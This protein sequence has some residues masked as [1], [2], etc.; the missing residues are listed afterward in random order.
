MGTEV[1]A[2]KAYSKTPRYLRFL[3]CSAVKDH[4]RSTTIAQRVTMEV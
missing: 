4:L 1:Y 2:E 3:R